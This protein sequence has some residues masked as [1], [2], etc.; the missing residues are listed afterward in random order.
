[1]ITVAIIEDN[2]LVR[3]GMADMLDAV[4]DMEV[5]LATTSFQSEELRAAKPRVVLMDI[6]LQ[7]DDCLDAAAA[8]RREIP[9]ANVIVM[10]LMPVHEEIAQLVDA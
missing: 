10:D 2:R 3:E 5:V 1:L 4:P 9:D 8:V 7:A 6:G